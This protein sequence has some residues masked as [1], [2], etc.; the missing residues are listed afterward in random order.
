MMGM[1]RS[2]VSMRRRRRKLSD[3]RGRAKTIATARWA[4]P[5]AKAPR[6]EA[7]G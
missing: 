6:R 7:T 2:L 5:D 1:G 3:E 4:R